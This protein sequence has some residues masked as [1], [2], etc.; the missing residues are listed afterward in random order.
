M[1]CYLHKVLAKDFKRETW[2]LKKPIKNVKDR[3]LISEG[4]TFVKFK[5]D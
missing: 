4:G 3:S 1:L 5:I 2:K